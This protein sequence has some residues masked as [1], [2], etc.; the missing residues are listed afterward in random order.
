MSSPE[1]HQKIM[2]SLK[3]LRPTFSI[4]AGNET[5]V[6]AG[7]SWLHVFNQ[8]RTIGRLR[9]PEEIF[10]FYR[11]LADGQRN[12][13]TG[14]GDAWSKQAKIGAQK[15]TLSLRGGSLSFGKNRHCDCDHELLRLL[16]DW[17]GLA[18]GDEEVREQLLAKSGQIG[19]SSSSGN[20]LLSLRYD[21]A[22]ALARFSPEQGRIFCQ[23]LLDMAD[24]PDNLM[25]PLWPTGGT[26]Q[27][28]QGSSYN[29]TGILIGAPTGGTFD[30]SKVDLVMLAARVKAAAPV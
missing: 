28:V 17:Y 14:C 21:N 23:T 15:V 10:A 29:Q 24:Q 18:T 26:I 12:L 9:G 20:L 30:A 8:N 25:S 4:R 16:S 11:L 22:A 27:F 6:S 1:K 5:T 7:L 2:R 19:C 13:A 3:E